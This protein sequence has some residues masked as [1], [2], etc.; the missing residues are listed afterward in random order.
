MLHLALHLQG[1]PSLFKK[2][3]KK[4]WGQVNTFALKKGPNMTKDLYTKC[5]LALTLLYKLF[6]LTLSWVWWGRCEKN[7]LP[8]EERR[9]GGEKKARVARPLG[10][11]LEPGTCRVLG[12][13][14]Q[15]HTMRVV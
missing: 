11:G 9:E 5:W 13:G 10:L 3:K 1:G 8:K 7:Y 12:E 4:I 2:K 6:T 14:P 15:L